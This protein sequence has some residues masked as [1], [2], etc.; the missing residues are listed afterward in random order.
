M[1]RQRI[2]ADRLLVARGQCESGAAARALILAGC[3]YQ[4]EIRITKAGALLPAATDPPVRRPP[5]PR[6]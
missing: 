5:H 6:G 1:I 4:G 2:R 3:V